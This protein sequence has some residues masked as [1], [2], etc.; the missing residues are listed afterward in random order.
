HNEKDVKVENNNRPVCEY[1]VFSS[2]F[3]P[4]QNSS[5]PVKIKRPSKCSRR[6]RRYRPNGKKHVTQENWKV[7]G[8]YFRCPSQK[9][10]DITLYA[11]GN[12]KMKINC[13]ATYPLNVTYIRALEPIEHETDQLAGLVVRTED[14]APG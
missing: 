9:M 4:I 11:T 1:E 2:N 14:I 13:R 7:D 6:Y 12:P 10:S 3:I 8:W 5:S